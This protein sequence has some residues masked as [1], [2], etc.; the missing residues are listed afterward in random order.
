MRK[1]HVIAVLLMTVALVV[2]MSGMVSANSYKFKG[3]CQYNGN[4]ITSD[5]TSEEFAASQSDLEPGDDLAYKVTYTNNS[6]RT[7]YWYMRNSVLET[8]EEAKKQAENGGYTYVLKNIGPDGTET[9]LFDN[10]EVGGETKKADLEGLKQATNATG[11]FFYI[12]ELKPGETGTTSLYVAL[13]GETEVNDYMD[14][15]GALMVSYAVEDQSGNNTEQPSPRTGDTMDLWKFILLMAAAV[16][17]AIL[18]IVSW[19]RDR[20]DGEKA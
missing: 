7:T 14:T 16:A 8:L 11:N 4:E 12:Q 18:A 1:T 9:T 20:K 19:R 17:V 2:A 10:S 6:N 3:A 13:D 5:F 15:R